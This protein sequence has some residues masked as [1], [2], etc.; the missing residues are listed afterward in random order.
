MASRP[1]S[2]RAFRIADRRHPLLDGTG[3]FLL[4]GR[5][6]SPG[7]RVIHAAETYAGA[8]LEILVHTNTGRIPHTHAWIEITCPTRYGIQEVKSI[9]RPTR[10]IG[11]EWYAQKRALILLVPSV[12]TAGLERNILINQDHPAFRHVRATDPQ[13]V[14]WDAR[15]FKGA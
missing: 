2:L 3:T 13:P 8:L 4:G 7:R 12:V 1:D 14:D 5:W 9:D 15:L 6:I 10:E 11:D